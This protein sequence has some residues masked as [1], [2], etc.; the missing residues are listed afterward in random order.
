MKIT[1]E[2]QRLLNVEQT[3]EQAKNVGGSGTQDFEEV[4]LKQ[5]SGQ[6]SQTGTVGAD[7][8]LLRT[9]AD[10]LRLASIGANILGGLDCAE[11]LGDDKAETDVDQVMQNLLGGFTSSMD[12]L[13]AFASS[14]NSQAPNALKT[15]WNALDNLDVNLDFLRKELGRLPQANADMEAVLNEME[16]LA[17]TERFKFNRGDYLS[18]YMA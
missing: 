5:I 12:S 18:D 4:L 11:G 7:P 2:L 9:R 10:P 17:V 14:L 6:Q 3:R 1:D 16:I 13:A 8:N 15:A